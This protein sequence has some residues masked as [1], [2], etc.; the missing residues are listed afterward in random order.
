ML[1]DY[2]PIQ[3]PVCDISSKKVNYGNGTRGDSTSAFEVK[4]HSDNITDRK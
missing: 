2:A 1:D 3:L 4:C